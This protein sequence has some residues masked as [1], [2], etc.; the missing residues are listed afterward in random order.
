M[1]AKTIEDKINRTWK[2]VCSEAKIPPKTEKSFISTNTDL[3]TF[4]HLIKT[5]KDGPELR[6]RPII[7]NR[8]GP[9]HKLSWLFSRLLRPLM[10]FLPTNLEN[11][12]ELLNNIRE[13]SETSKKDYTYPF[14]LYV[15]S[16]YTSVPPKDAINVL[17]EKLTESKLNLPLSPKQ[18]DAILTVIFQNTFF[19]FDDKIYRQKSGLPMGNST[20]AILAILY[21]DRLEAQAISTCRLIGF[22]RRYVDDI[23]VITNDKD[24]AEAILTF[25]NNADPNIKFEIE[26]PTDSNSISLLDFR[27]TI[28]RNGDAEFCFFKKMAKKNVFPHSNSAIPQGCKTN[29]I[30]NEVMRINERCSEEENRCRHTQDFMRQ[31]NA[32]GYN[33]PE[34]LINQ[35][36]KPNKTHKSNDYCYFEFPYINED[37]HQAVRRIF[38]A[39]GLPVRIY[40]K[41]SNLRSALKKKPTGQAC[42][43][44]DCTLSNHLCLKKNCVYSMKCRRCQATYIGSTK[45]TLHQRVKE[46]HRTQSS[47]IFQHISKCHSQFDVSIVTSDNKISRLRLKEA[48]A[49]RDMNPSINS[50]SE[51]EEL[52]NLIF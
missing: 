19:R 5:H 33:N 23:L 22:Y 28:Q 12:L 37:T 25:M 9:S 11:S 39:A 48:I 40:S 44:K 2:R 29:A 15:V 10:T 32:R 14:S 34:A 13:R 51:K 45:R 46:H 41:N 8:R 36:R 17:T 52:L 3:P 18:I 38:K 1:S 6:I 7:S 26:H 42:N 4:Y 27:V 35:R 50:K 16:L 43:I 20:S 47:S 24:S 30:K 49:I 21:M 31:L